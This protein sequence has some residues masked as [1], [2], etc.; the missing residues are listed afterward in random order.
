MQSNQK[1]R[2][3]DRIKNLFKRTSQGPPEPALD[4]TNENASA[5]GLEAYGDRERTKARYREAAN[6]LTQA[7]K[8]NGDNWETLDFPELSGEPERFDD[9]QFQ[10]KINTVLQAR[11][12][13]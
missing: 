3:R 9:L 2:K 10:D 6:L 8:G 12:N 11:K 1:P 13:A 7:V 4:Q 5:P